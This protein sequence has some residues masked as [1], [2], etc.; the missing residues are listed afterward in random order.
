MGHKIVNDLVGTNTCM[1]SEFFLFG[2]YSL[3]VLNKILWR[4]ELK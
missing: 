4:R 2:M 1:T 3:G